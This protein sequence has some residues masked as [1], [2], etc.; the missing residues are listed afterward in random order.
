[1]EGARISGGNRTQRHEAVLARWPVI[2]EGWALRIEGRRT[3]AAGPGRPP[4]GPPAAGT[5]QVTP[6]TAINR[7]MG[8]PDDHGADAIRRRDRTG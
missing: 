1:V 8:L 6:L 3:T 5:P 7:A 2:G 4:A